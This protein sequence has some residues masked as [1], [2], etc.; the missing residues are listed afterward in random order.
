MTECRNGC[1][2]KKFKS[3]TA[4][5]STE[6]MG[7]LYAVFMPLQE[8]IEKIEYYIENERTNENHTRRKTPHR[9]YDTEAING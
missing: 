6:W 7:E 9:Q 8:R 3:K 5:I 4:T 1:W 2:C